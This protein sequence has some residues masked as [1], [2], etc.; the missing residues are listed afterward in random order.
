M[1]ICITSIGTANPAF[2]IKQET[3]AGFMES[4]HLLNDPQA[5]RL[6]ALYRATGI[7]ERYTVIEDYDRENG[8]FT[9]FPNNTDL[10]PFPD[11]S[12]RMSLFKSEAPVLAI[13]SA[14]KCLEKSRYD[15]FSGITHL[16]SVSC[17]GMYAPGLDVDLVN[18]LGIKKS[19][20]RTCINFMGCYAAFNALKVAYEI[21]LGQSAAKVLVVCTELCSLHFQ[22]ENKEDNYLAN[23]LFGDGAASAIIE[24]VNEPG[25]WFALKSFYCD[26]LPTGAKEMAWNIDNFGFEMKLS[27]YVPDVIKKGI[28]NLIAGLMNQP[29]ASGSGFDKYAIHPGGKKILREIENELGIDKKDNFAAYQILQSFGNMSS[30]TILFVLQLLFDELRAED[31]H[32]EVLALAFGPGLTLESMILKVY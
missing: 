20:H 13:N 17:T 6:K 2:K 30:P 11:T 5:Q 24:S 14:K 3:I 10:E 7:K 1:E 15:D 18:G 8:N 28:K 27:A 12:S 31:A 23:A 21:C 25:N 29:T 19:V 22:K 9:F 32:Q 4:A 26:I 16:I